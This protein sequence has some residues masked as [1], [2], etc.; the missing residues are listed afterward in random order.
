MNIEWAF[1]TLEG[2]KLPNTLEERPGLK[3]YSL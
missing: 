3:R 1:K 2:G